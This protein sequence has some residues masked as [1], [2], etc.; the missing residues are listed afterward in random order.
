MAF[1]D[2]PP[3]WNAQRPSM[4]Q[5]WS[6][7]NW[8]GKTAELGGKDWWSNESSWNANSWGETNSWEGN[9]KVGGNFTVKFLEI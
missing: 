9:K 4:A 8:A 7:Q 3:D 2:L 5:T 6:Q 1:G